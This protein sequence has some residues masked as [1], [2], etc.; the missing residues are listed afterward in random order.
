MNYQPKGYRSG[1]S[2]ELKAKLIQKSNISLASL[3][4]L[5]GYQS[6][7][8]LNPEEVSQL[9]NEINQFVIALYLEGKPLRVNKVGGY[10]GCPD[11]KIYTEMV[12]QNT[13]TTLNFCFT[14]SGANQF[15]DKFISIVNSRTDKLLRKKTN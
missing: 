3:K 10:Q 12:E 14:C 6:Q 13:V 4:L 7:F 5:Y 8:R 15:E 1:L 11:T 9:E 2:D